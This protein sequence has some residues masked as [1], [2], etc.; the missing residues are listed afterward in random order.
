MSRTGDEAGDS[1]VEDGTKRTRWK[2]KGGNGKKGN[3]K[4]EGKEKK[5]ERGGRR[6][7]KEKKRNLPEAASRGSGRKGGEL[8]WSA[9]VSKRTNW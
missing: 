3:K 1:K 6:E 9:S 7:G 4:K 8:E 2:N 5:R